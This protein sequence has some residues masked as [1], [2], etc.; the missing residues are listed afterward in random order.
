MPS[1]TTPHLFAPYQLRS[2]TLANRVVVSPMCQY[3]A[4]DGFPDDWHFVHLG[5]RAIGGASLVI[6]EASA[7]LP[8]GRITPG[9]LGL[10]DDAHI[11]AFARIVDFLHTHG[12]AA[13]IQLAH[14]G[15]KASMAVPWED[16]R[17]IPPAE[18]GWTN[19]FAPSS[20]PFNEHYPTPIELSLDEIRRIQHAFRDAAVRA[21]AA[22]FDVLEIHAAHGYLIHEFLSPASNHRT[23]QY[24]GSFDNRIRFLLETIHLVREVWPE[25]LPLF[26]RVSATDWLEFP[27][28]NP[29]FATQPDNLGWTVSQTVQLAHLLKD[30]AVD[31]ID[32]S[33]G[34]NISKVTIPVGPG[35]QTAFAARIKHETHLPTATVGMISS[36]EQADQIVRTHQAD[37]VLLARE[38]LRDPYWP[39]RAAQQ[40]RFDIS[41]P[42]QYV[43]AAA[44]RRPARQPFIPPTR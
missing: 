28:S 2:L 10:W 7:V 20:I 40:L 5:S 11:P 44:G 17:V 16:V 33:S 30:H 3:C 12:S 18:G 35:Y 22:G 14:A 19:V 15:R 6:T 32:V 26:V 43:R 38:L 41:W 39:L 9:D 29:D 24:G 4:H 36:P 42:V 1:N 21:L 8:E 13:G 23:D 25:S 37:L 34:G 27:E 31:L